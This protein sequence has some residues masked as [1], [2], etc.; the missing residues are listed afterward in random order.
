MFVLL[1]MHRKSSWPH[2]KYRSVR[3]ETGVR[4]RRINIVAFRNNRNSLRMLFYFRFHDMLSAKKCHRKKVIKIKPFKSIC[5]L[6]RQYSFFRKTSLS[7]S[8]FFHFRKLVARIQFTKSKQVLTTG[9]Y[10]SRSYRC[11]V[12]LMTYENK[13]IQII[14]YLTF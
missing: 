14:F 13:I 11:P 7:S 1:R 12:Y 6:A 2:S 8:C 4:L 10:R 3:N 9:L 5:F